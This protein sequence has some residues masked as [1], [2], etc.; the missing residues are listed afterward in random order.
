MNGHKV[1]LDSNI[2]IYLSKGVLN[3]NDIL[4]N[5][6]ELYISIITY[7]EV[8][9]YQ[10]TDEEEKEIIKNLLD[11]FEMINI[12]PGIAGNVLSI[13]QKKRLNYLMR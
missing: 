8:L 11:R 13:R 10:F 9:G 5:Y 12:D 2:I 4:E 7:L 6:D 3:I 1:V